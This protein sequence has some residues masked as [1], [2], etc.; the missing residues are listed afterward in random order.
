MPTPPMFS[1]NRLSLVLAIATLT[2]SIILFQSAS[3]AKDTPPARPAPAVT[4]SVIEK[5][6]VRTWNTFSGR[7]SAVA[8]AR[9]RP[10]VGGEVQQVLFE[11]GQVVSKGEPLFIID[12][13]PHQAALD[14]AQAQLQAARANAKLAQDEFQRSEQLLKD[15]LISRSQHDAATTT[16]QSAEAAVNEAK[17]LLQQ[18]KLNLDY[19]NITAPINGRISRAEITE[20]NIVEA[21]PNAPVLAAVV[22]NDQ[23]YVEF[24]VDEATYIKLARQTQQQQMPIEVQL[25]ENDD[26]VYQGHFHAFDNQ[27]DSATGTIRARAIVENSDHVLAAGMYAHVRLG[28]VNKQEVVLVPES[29]IGTNQSRKFVLVVDTENTARYREVALGEQWQNLRIIN[30]GLKEGDRVIVNGLSHVRPD[31]PVNPSQEKSL[32]LAN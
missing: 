28:S 27:V 8:S 25:D 15:N 24:N 20:G 10:L 26:V 3:A 11:E 16:Q 21:G 13:R 14:R 4:V 32:A 9:I 30:Q 1:R 2:G 5:Q 18:A 17:A 6:S 31:T 22:A 29:A 19:A 12:P 23:F 7:L